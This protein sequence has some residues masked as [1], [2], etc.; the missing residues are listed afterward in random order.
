MTI[1]TMPSTISGYSGEDAYFVGQKREESFE[2]L[3]ES[4]AFR[5]ITQCIQQLAEVFN[6]CSIKGW[7]GEQAIPISKEVLIWTIKILRSF[8]LGI[9]PPEIGAEPDGAISLE[10][11]RSPDRVISIS[12]NP[13]GC[14]YY[15]AIIGIK[16]RKGMDT[17]WFD[18]SED[19]LELISQVTRDR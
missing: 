16:R 4:N 6:E 3:Q 17:A 8:P 19:L 14:L 9:E 18:V 7:D 15:A 1:N 2:L 10:W 11:Y 13:D 5:F 12:V